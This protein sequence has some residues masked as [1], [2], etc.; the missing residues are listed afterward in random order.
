[1][2]NDQRPAPTEQ[3]WLTL[4]WQRLT[5]EART[6]MRWLVIGRSSLVLGLLLVALLLRVL[7][8]GGFATLDELSFWVKRSETFLNV[9]KAG[10]FGGTAVT[11][12]PGVTTMWLGAIGILLRRAL[13][14]WEVV[15]AMPFPLLLALMRLPVALV[16]TAG[17]M[18]GYGLLRRLLPFPIALFAALL[19]AT[20]PFIVAFSRIL[21]VD[22]LAMTF[23][24]LSLLAACFYWYHQRHPAAL[25]LSAACAALGVLSK[26]PA[27]VI[28]PVIGF[29]AITGHGVWGTRR[30][31]AL[32]SLFLVLCA[33]SLVF[34]ATL[35]IVWPAIWADPMRV[36]G[37]LRFGVEA[38]G[39]EPHMQGNFF[40]GRPDDTPG[41]P[42]YPVALAMRLTPWAMAGLFLLP[43]AM[44]R[45]VKTLEHTP[46]ERSQGDATSEQVLHRDIAALALFCILFIV[47]MSLFPKKFNRYLVLIF[48][49]INILAAVGWGGAIGGVRS[50][51]ERSRGRFQIR[52]Y[53]PATVRGLL[54]VIAV[55]AMVNAAWWHPYGVAYFNPLLGGAQAGARTFVVGWGEGTEQVA[56]WLNQQPNITGVTVASTILSTIQPYLIPGAQTF[57]PVE[58]ELP[59]D[60]G[61]VV[62]YIRHPQR[63]LL[64]PPFDAYYPRRT[65]LFTATIHSVDYAWVY[66]VPPR[67]QHPMDVLFG[68]NIHFRG[69]DL[70][71]AAVQSSGVLSVTTHWQASAPVDINY[72]QFI[73]VLDAQGQRLGQ[74]DA[75]PCGPD[76]PTGS[77]QPLRYMTWVHPVPVSADLST[78]GSRGRGRF[79]TYPYWLSIGLYEPDSFARLPVQAPVPPD[80]PDAGSNALLIPLWMNDQ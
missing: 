29:V 25:V 1:M 43:L 20:D 18:V 31:F 46:L 21:H 65:P 42:F 53:H 74:T 32:R 49:A 38:E 4:P 51:L 67:I 3:P 37:Q 78:E 5:N 58:P 44:R 50:M 12:H 76:A 63:K 11:S 17:I 8:L 24:N 26:S 56:A 77:W 62:V 70:D 30:F 33:W 22:G 64:E 52:P 80:A 35:A 27:L 66:Q 14:A 13:V 69:Y 16:H 75:P 61:Y 9:L 28:L 79:Q 72:M 39:A 47:A 54:P 10:D 71:A 59:P 45:G 48:P 40:M 23:T 68:Q 60:T 41:W 73:H 6:N 36:Y 19:W 2:T 15:P 7:D 55:I 57:T 34:L